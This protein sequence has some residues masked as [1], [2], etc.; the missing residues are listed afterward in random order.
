MRTYSASR[1]LKKYTQTQTDRPGTCRSYKYIGMFG[2][3][4]EPVLRSEAVDRSV[5]APSV[6]N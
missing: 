3:V 4:I 2:V 6:A 1:V 5:T